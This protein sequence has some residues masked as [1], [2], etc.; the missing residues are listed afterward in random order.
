VGSV[1]AG[2][3]GRASPHLTLLGSQALHALACLAFLLPVGAGAL[4]AAYVVRNAF[5]TGVAPVANA[6]LA[7]RARPAGRAR[8]QAYASLAWNLGWATGAAAGGIL[9]GHLAGALFPLAA[10]LGVAGS[11]LGILALTRGAASPSPSR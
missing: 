6:L 2:R 1:A 8:A 7:H 3:L 5:A 4:G 11:A 10:L 9:L